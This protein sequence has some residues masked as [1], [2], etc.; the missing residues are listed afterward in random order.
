VLTSARLIDAAWYRWMAL[1]RPAY[2]ANASATSGAPANSA[3]SL[4]DDANR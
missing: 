3:P 2:E 4:N 1:V